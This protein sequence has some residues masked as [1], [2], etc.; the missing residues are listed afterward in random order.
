MTIGN[1]IKNLRTAHNLTQQEF[2]AKIYISYQSISNWENHHS[3]PSTEIMLLIIDTFDLPLNYF[4]DKDIDPTTNQEE[5]LILSSFLK[6]M[7]TSRDEAPTL[8]VVQ[9]LS[10]LPAERVK[11][12][13]PS[14][15]DLVYTLINKVDQDIKI[16]VEKRLSDHESVLSIFINDMIPLLYHKR[17]TLHLLYTRPYIKGV[18]T[19]FIK[20]KYQSLLIKYNPQIKKND[21]D[22]AYLIETLTTF[23]S[24]WLSRPE[25][26]PLDQFQQRI[27][28]LVNHSMSSWRL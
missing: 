20:A 3:Y 28:H 24:I 10:G 2:A 1:Q 27:T 19:Q 5:T 23:I 14:Y 12:Y 9:Q 22:T 4:M 18:W 8:K 11:H 15:D 25:I 13:F 21:L 16:R 7:T 6:C 17:E 26:E